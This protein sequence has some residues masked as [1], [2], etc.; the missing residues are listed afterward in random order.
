M[1]DAIAAEWL[2]FRSLRSNSQLLAASALSV[3]LCAGIAFV[4]AKGLDGQS[5]Q[6]Q[7][8]FSSIGAG[9]G[10]GFP[11][12][13]FVMG[14]LGALSITSEHATGLIRTSL[15]SVPSRQLFLFAKV[16]PLAV[17]SLVAGQVLVFGMHFAAMAVL[18]DRAGLVLLDGRTLGASLA[19]PGVLP[20]LLVA[21]AV[22]PVVAVIGLGLG[23]VIRSTAATLV[24]L[25]VLLFVLPMGAQVVA[26]PWRSRIG[27]LMIQNLPDQIVGGEAP[28]ILAPWAALALLIAYPV[29][30]L[31]G[32]AVVIGRR[33]RR[34]LAIGGLVT[35]LLAA[36]VAVPPGAAAIT[37]KWQPCG[38]ELECSAI[39]VPVDW[40]KP[41]GR[42]ISIDL[43][44][45]PATGTHR[46]IGTA[47]ALPGGPGGSGIDDLEKSAGNFADLRERFDVVSFAPRN[48]TDLGVIP[49]DCLAGGPWLTVPENPAEFEEL[50]ERNW[51]AVERC[52]SADPEFFD[53]LDAAS[54]ARDAEAARKALGEEQLSFIATS[55]GGTTAVSYARLYPDRVRAMY[56]DG[57][58]SHIDGVE[59]AIRNKDRV[60][61]SQFAEFTTW[62]ATSTDCALRG[63]DAGAVW[64]DLVAAADRSPIPV[65]GE[66]AA[67]TG[68]D[69]KVAAAPD[70]ISPGQAPDFP[71]WQRFARAVDRAAAGDAAGFS[72]YVQDVTGS[73]KVPAFVGM[74]ATHCADGRG[75]AD[76]A[77]FQ[78]LKE[79]DER[80]SPNFAG[81][82]LW[83]PLA[84]VGWRNPVR[85]PPAPL[86]ADQLP[87]L[88]GVGTLV[89]FDGPAS[90][91]RAVPGSAAVQFKG[92]GHAL[93][94]TGDACTIA[95]ANR[96][97]AFGRTPPP[98]TTCEPPEST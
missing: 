62:C 97:L 71:N 63:R 70:L 95:H 84:C 73:P 58:S 81:N 16:P 35:A 25:I 33:R 87:P 31:T 4:M 48:T 85:N 10:T 17:I 44:R 21:G 80:L 14:A 86:P 45:L 90:A 19:D 77:E 94:L 74:S 32:A 79:L 51:A 29:A 39:E 60:I 92:F 22:M 54:V 47:F 88:L 11:V 61:E 2:K 53:N 7:L 55:Y 34:P 27:S 65:R 43:A 83:H 59:T 3:L 42:K 57:T 23:A 82:S 56:L 24:T 78:R 89:D 20:G 76:F 64:R 15:V 28:G 68:F 93:Y 5:A 9:L 6:E 91:A 72:R 50:G 96:Y 66:R 40:S 8:R 38:G 69:L 26:D 41:D 52:R 46:R 30:A 1:R 12:A 18:G 36:V 67:F 13:C 49:F 37:L 98:G 75:F